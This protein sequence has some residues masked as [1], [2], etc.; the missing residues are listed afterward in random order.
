MFKS[1]K[2]DL[3]A[4]DAEW[5][6]DPDAGRALHGCPADMPDRDVVKEMWQRNGATEDDPRPFLKLSM[7]RVVSI[8]MVMRHRRGDGRVALQ[9]RSQPRNPASPDDCRESTILSRFLASIGSR[10]PQL[11]GF[12]SNGSDLPIMI[13][14]GIVKG[15]RAGGFCKRP[16]KPWEGRDYFAR[17]NE[18]NVDLMSAIGGRG[19]ATPSLVEMAVLSGIPGKIDNF[20]GGA[21]AEAWLEGEVRRIVR[22]NEHDAISTYLVWLR[23]AH[24]AGFVS[25]EEYR[26][27][28][29]QL[30]SLLADRAQSPKNEHLAD[31]IDEWD[32][33]RALTGNS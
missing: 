7:C 17:E 22:Y 21:V 29:A 18:W 1:V 28:Q 9:L 19:K 13:Q 33:L 11:V 3:W 31:Y 24:F 32:R 20:D 26:R 12:N 15:V 4:F 16:N 30:R 8:A 10:G 14:R 23:V 6:P 5:V 2:D 25:A 27:E